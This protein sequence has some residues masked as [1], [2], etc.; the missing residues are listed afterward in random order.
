MPVLFGVVL[1]DLIGFGIVIPI[2]PFLSPQLGASKLDIAFIIATYAVGAG[3]CGPLWGRL[4]DRI[5]RKPVIMTCLAGAALSYVLLAL[6][7]SLWMVYAARGFAGLMAGNLGVASAMMADITEPE[8]RARGMGVIGAAFG[9]GMVLGPLLGGLLSGGQAAFT[10]PCIV[11]GIMSLLAILAAAVFL[12]E[13]LPARNQD[14]SRLPPGGGRSVST[15]AVL[16]AS[17]IRLLVLQFGI[18][19]L[20]V[21]SLTYLFPLW[22]G[23]LLGWGARQVGIVFGVQGA[24][25]VVVQGGLM[26]WL[27][28]KLGELQLL[29]IAVTALALGLLTAAF[30]ADMPA[31]LASVFVGMTGATLCMPLLNAIASQRTPAASR[32]RVLG[33]TGSVASWGRVAGP[34]LAGGNLVLLG[35]RGAWLGALLIC[36]IYVFWCYREY[37]LHRRGRAWPS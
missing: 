31:M 23:D 37:A 26:G 33:T 32:G 34:L 6:A 4:S 24:I 11:A 18:H 12:P 22:A 16:R 3:L 30:A 20:C 15:Y 10:L 35:Y 28:A 25:M 8:Q 5:G 36:L 14:H 17:G 1:L 9:L 27:V 2:L 7:S 21:S 13:S 19:N 29:R